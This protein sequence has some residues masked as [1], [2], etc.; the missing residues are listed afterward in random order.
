[1]KRGAFYYHNQYIFQIVQIE[2]FNACI[3]ADN[4]LRYLVYF[5]AVWNGRGM[6]GVPGTAAVTY[7]LR[8]G[9]LPPGT[10]H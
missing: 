10:R 5:V 6:E 2:A 4:E 9:Q 3:W 1:M 8:L 7:L